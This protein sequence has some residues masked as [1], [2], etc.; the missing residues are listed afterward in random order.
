MKKKFLDN[1]FKLAKDEEPLKWYSSYE[2]IYDYFTNNY[3]EGYN[4]KEDTNKLLDY[5]LMILKTYRDYIE[6]IEKNND[7]LIDCIIALITIIGIIIS[8]KNYEVVINYGLKLIGAYFTFVIGFYIWRKTKL[9][10]SY[11]IR[12]CNKIIYKLEDLK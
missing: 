5:D 7:Y 8:L 10:G 4:K 11:K 9:S 12:V 2:R 3:L 1:S 6:S